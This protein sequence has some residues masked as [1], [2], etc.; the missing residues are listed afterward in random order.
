MAFSLQFERIMT[1]PEVEISRVVGNLTEPKS[2][3][4][5]FD[6]RNLSKAL[7]ALL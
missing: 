7:R 1:W 5:G 2:F 6:R 3:C 4:S